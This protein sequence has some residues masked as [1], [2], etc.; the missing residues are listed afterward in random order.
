V[1]SRVLGQANPSILKTLVETVTK[2][3]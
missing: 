3:A 1:A 2:G